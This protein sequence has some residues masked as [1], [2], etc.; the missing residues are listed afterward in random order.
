M[1]FPAAVHLSR[2]LPLVPF[3]KKK[4]WTPNLD[5][6]ECIDAAKQ[7]VIVYG[8][9]PQ[10]LGTLLV[11]GRR[12]LRAEFILQVPTD[13]SPMQAKSKPNP[14]QIQA[15]LNFRPEIH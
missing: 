1:R 9:H 12:S 11:S 6:Q 7:L 5:C 14:S 13:A 10:S 15:Y 4:G 2:I 3:G 8:M